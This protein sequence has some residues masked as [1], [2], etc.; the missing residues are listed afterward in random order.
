[1]HQLFTENFGQFAQSILAERAAAKL[2]PYAFFALFRAEA[3]QLE[4]AMDFL[5]QIKQLIPLPDRQLQVLGPIPATMAKRAGRY[6]VQLLLQASQRPYLQRFLK[7]LVIKIEKIPL[8]SRVRWSL[9]ID[10]ME[11]F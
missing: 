9:D 5:Q 11:M 10:P 1:M 2:P 7:E 6:R 8:K 4:K 3:H